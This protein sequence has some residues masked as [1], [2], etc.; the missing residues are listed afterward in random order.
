MDFSN[1]SKVQQIIIETDKK[2]KRPSFLCQH[3]NVNDSKQLEDRIKIHLRLYGIKV[4]I[5]TCS[6]ACM[7]SVLMI[8]FRYE[9][10]IQCFQCRGMIY[11]NPFLK[12]VDDERVIFCSELCATY[13][14]ID[15]IECMHV[16]SS[17]EYRSHLM[18]FRGEVVDMRTTGSSDLCNTTMAGLFDGSNKMGCYECKQPISDPSI[19]SEKSFWLDTIEN[20]SYSYCSN[21]CK[22]IIIRNCN[23]FRCNACHQVGY[24]KCSR[25]I[26]RSETDVDNLIVYYCSVECQRQDWPVHKLVCKKI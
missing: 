4:L 8:I 10:G 11:N 5:G 26:Q 3:I 19:N 9:K 17:T 16:D 25:C 6:L 12:E 1:E 24:L 14:P 15:A 18:G 23:K 13:F 2:K 21:K 7:A 20:I 22:N